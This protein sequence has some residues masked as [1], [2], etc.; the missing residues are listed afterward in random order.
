MKMLFSL[1]C[2]I[3]SLYVVHCSVS[4]KKSFYLAC[5]AQALHCP[6]VLSVHDTHFYVAE[7]EGKTIL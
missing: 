5:S 1:E 6:Y 2:K 7:V 3:T 4:G